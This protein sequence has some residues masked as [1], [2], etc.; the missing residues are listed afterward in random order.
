MTLAVICQFTVATGFR[1]PQ[2]QTRFITRTGGLHDRLGLYR[3]SDAVYKVTSRPTVRLL[4][5]PTDTCEAKN[6]AR[7][8]SRGNGP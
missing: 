8:T 4:K 1:N 2:E 3:G 6:D 7:R 5:V